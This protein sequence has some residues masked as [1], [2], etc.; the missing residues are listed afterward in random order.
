MILLR[1]I[2]IPHAH[3]ALALLSSTVALH[4]RAGE[5]SF[6]AVV[7]YA[8]GNSPRQ[9]A[10]AD[11]NGDGAPD[12]VTNDNGGGPGRITILLNDGTG[13]FRSAVFHGAP[14]GAA[15]AVGDL[16]ADGDLDI[17]TSG[18]PRN[19][20]YE[21]NGEGDLVENQFRPSSFRANA[22]GLCDYDRDGDPD[23]GIVTA[24]GDV[25]V[26]TNLGAGGFDKFSLIGRLADGCCDTFAPSVQ[27]LDIR[28]D[29][30]LE[31]V[32]SSYTKPGHLR[33]EWVGGKRLI[34]VKASNLSGVADIVYAQFDD[35]SG[36]DAAYITRDATWGVRFACNDGAAQLD[37]CPTFGGGVV[38]FPA[39]IGAAD[40]DQDG[41]SDLAVGDPSNVTMSV[42]HRIETGYELGHHSSSGLV[43]LHDL[44]C[45][46]VNGDGKP[47]IVGCG[48]GFVSV[49]LNDSR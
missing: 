8:A 36:I 45:S 42:L 18:S 22:V 35:A 49:F 41:M 37:Y 39:C 46:D 23:V 27:A 11:M 32:I 4:S 33:L 7:N 43:G 38:G 20:W 29:G 34:P 21:N 13:R 10:V 15:F 25:E 28:G 5:I 6:A 17:V 30:T 40:F 2:V 9:V 16:D 44:V 24:F 12:I 47:D 3:I 1:S 14:D 31:F 48:I 26:A 19:Y